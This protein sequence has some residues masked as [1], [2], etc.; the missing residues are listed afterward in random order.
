MKDQAIMD[1][2]A[3]KRI[4]LDD[5][6]DADVDDFDDESDFYA[7]SYSPEK[8]DPYKASAQLDLQ[9]AS[10]EIVE[11]A[12]TSAL[13]F[14]SSI[15][16]LGT[17]TAQGGFN[18]PSATH[19]QNSVKIDDLKE[20][21][22]DTS[23]FYVSTPK[24]DKTTLLQSVTTAAIATNGNVRDLFS[25]YNND[26]TSPD[27]NHSVVKT[28]SIKDEENPDEFDVY[29]QDKQDNGEESLQSSKP[30]GVST[31]KDDQHDVLVRDEVSIAEG[32]ATGGAATVNMEQKPPQDFID[33]AKANKDDP[34]AEWRFDSSDAESEASSSSDSSSDDS[35]E[36]SGSEDEGQLLDPAEQ[37]RLLMQ[38]DDG[39]A[40][41]LSKP[42]NEPLEKYLPKPDITITPDMP[43]TPVGV[44]DHVV[45]RVAVIKADTSGEYKV[46]D[47]GSALC[48]RDRTVIGVTAETLGPVRQPL[49]T[50]GF[51]D[52]AELIE[53][54][55]KVGTPVFYVDEHSKFVF[56]QPLQAYKGNDGPNLNEVHDEELLE[57]E[58]EFSDD[59]KEAQYKREKKQQNR[60][61]DSGSADYDR[62]SETSHAGNRGGR[63]GK[64]G[65]R[66][67]FQGPPNRKRG[68]PDSALASAP[69]VI[70]NYDDDDDANDDMYQPLRRPDNL[71]ELMSSGPPP[72]PRFRDDRRGNRR[73]NNAGNFRG[74]RGQG[75]FDRGK[76]GRGGFQRGGRGGHDGDQSSRSRNSSA[77]RH[78]PKRSPSATRH[79]GRERSTEQRY[80]QHPNQQQKHQHS[81]PSHQTSDNSYSP[82]PA[83][84][85]QSQ[86][87]PPPAQPKSSNY[88]QYAPPPPP[89]PVPQ[90]APV[91]TPAIPAGAHLNPAFFM[92][93]NLLQTATQGQQPQNPVASY[94]QQQGYAN[95][96]VAA[97]YGNQQAITAALQQLQQ[98]AQAPAPVL[99][100]PQPQAWGG[101]ANQAPQPSF[102]QNRM[103]P[104]SD[105][106]ES[107]EAQERLRLLVESLKGQGNNGWEQQHQYR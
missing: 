92:L 11:P 62:R 19:P 54:G 79:Q 26:I 4:R 101:Y 22:D 39:E 40:N 86:Y 59:E 30:V 23:D 52:E 32:D 56:T 53:T 70:I 9:T 20:E 85:Q 6:V 58:I 90:I 25:S 72:P 44:V 10:L 55:L 29:Q 5:P 17:P 60:F 69:S 66:G 67:G 63:G 71:Q 100:S 16:G 78:P 83:Q 18:L 15:P 61:N 84:M 82:N 14:T 36:D 24:D 37:A 74:G 41:G 13:S 45:G 65:G 47:M 103:V 81:H 8:K 80:D 95:P 28:D 33:A 73:G 89:P 97:P 49:Y 98:Q 94:P 96:P 88:S 77:Q 105:D 43:I 93:Q 7:D 34:A 48:L 12:P 1:E 35:D 107:R 75:G 42:D 99:P 27:K 50:V 64:R 2:P 106:R 3:A 31:I 21:D 68:H 102:N 87:I 91:A 104:T 76:R 57:E 51:T 46:L 38:E